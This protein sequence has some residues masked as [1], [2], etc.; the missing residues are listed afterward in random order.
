[1]IEHA[2]YPTD[3]GYDVGIR[4]Q[5]ILGPLPLLRGDGQR[6][7]LLGREIVRP[8]FGDLLVSASRS[9]WLQL[10]IQ[11]TRIIDTESD[12]TAATHEFFK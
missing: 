10:P 4:F 9:C 1:M 6:T 8:S 11:N 12:Q 7:V 5:S 3:D 2:C